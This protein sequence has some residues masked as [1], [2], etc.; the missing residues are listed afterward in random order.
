MGR[1]HAQ[2]G[3]LWEQRRGREE[4]LESGDGERAGR[5]F[6]EVGCASDGDGGGSQSN[7]KRSLVG[8]SAAMVWTL[9]ERRQRSVCPSLLLGR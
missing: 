3:R 2:L 9:P 4:Q 5:G 6:V 7:R 8:A 1:E